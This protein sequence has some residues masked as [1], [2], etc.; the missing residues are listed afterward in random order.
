MRRLREPLPAA[1][2]KLLDQIIDAAL[3][4]AVLLHHI[5]DLLAGVDDS[6]VVPPAE[7]VADRLERVAGE[8]AADIHRH[9]AREYD[10]AGAAATD[11]L[12]HPNLIVVGDLFLNLLDGELAGGFFLQEIPQ[13]TLDRIQ[14]N[15]AVDQRVR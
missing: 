11:Q 5:L 13:Q 3:H 4:A 9:L 10:L 7:G 6:T 2:G 15:L 1:A 14:V 8:G 12:A